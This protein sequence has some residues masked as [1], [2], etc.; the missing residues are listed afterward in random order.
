MSCNTYNPFFNLG[1]EFDKGMDHVIENLPTPLLDATFEDLNKVLADYLI[2]IMN[3]TGSPQNS[4]NIA[5]SILPNAANSYQNA[6]LGN[7]RVFNETQMM[8][9][10]TLVSSIKNNDVEGIPKVLDETEEEIAKSG[11]NSE[12]Q[13]PLFLAVEMGKKSY[14]FWVTQI[15]AGGESD[16]ADFL[17]SN[18]AI[19]FANL[20]F[21]VV[22]SMEG[23]LSGYA[24]FLQMDM[25]A[26]NAYNYIGRSSTATIAMV[27]AVGISAGK[28]MFK[29]VQKPSIRITDIGDLN[30]DK[31][32]LRWPRIWTVS[33]TCSMF[34]SC[35]AMCDVGGSAQ[36][37]VCFA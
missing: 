16:W 17:N 13:A 24:Q 36:N 22:A 29:W 33:G 1:R 20:P 31:Y 2:D 14:D 27:A 9:F 10:S 7:D 8:L 26:G 23:S 35:R 32:K 12:Q 15:D 34:L 37:D 4:E 6:S 21:W 28:A 5:Y 19:N 3:S 25:A 18:A 11:L 30:D